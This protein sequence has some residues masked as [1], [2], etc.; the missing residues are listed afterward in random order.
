MV[1]IGDKVKRKDNK[2]TLY[3]IGIGKT[4]DKNRKMAWLSNHRGGSS[5]TWSYASNLRKVKKQYS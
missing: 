1:K 4:G 3:V 5:K 2:E